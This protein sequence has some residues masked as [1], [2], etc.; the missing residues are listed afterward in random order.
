[1]IDIDGD[2][3]ARRILDAAMDAFVLDGFAG[4]STDQIAAGAAAS[5]QTIY[6]RFGD[7]AGLF[8][9]LVDDFLTRV[10][11]QIVEVDVAGFAT[12]EEA[13]R[14][15]ARRLADSI[16]DKR[17][18]RLRRLIIAEAVRFPDIGRQYYD[19]AFTVTLAALADVLGALDAR[20][21]LRISDTGAAADHLA[22]LVLWVPSNRIMMTGRFDSV[23]AEEI[24]RAVE[25]A[26]RVFVAAYRGE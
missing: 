1:M 18:Q 13:V 22:G 24:D 10:R 5:K 4:T 16:L 9:A 20:G 15:L 25:S 17:V 23:S 14:V 21:L 7:K 3:V 8:H 19:G 26:V 12:A 6:K 11:A 2:P